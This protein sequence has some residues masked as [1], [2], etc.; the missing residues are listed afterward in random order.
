MSSA[1]RDAQ[2]FFGE[3]ARVLALA[4][5]IAAA[6]WPVPAS[7]QAVYGSIAGT[8]TDSTGA[9]LPGASVTVTSVERKTT[10]TVTA[11]ASGYYVKERL[12]PGSYEVKA[13]LSGFKS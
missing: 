9:T 10:D 3:P 6:G 8:V 12:I 1:L 11:N 7:A 13:E 2:R 4:V 5:V